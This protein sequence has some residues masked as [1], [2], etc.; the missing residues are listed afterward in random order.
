MTAKSPNNRAAYLTIGDFA[1]PWIKYPAIVGND[2]AGEVIEVGTGA[3]RFKIGDRVVALAVGTDKRSNKASES[4]FQECVVIRTHMA[5]QIPEFVSYEEVAVLPLALGTA[6]CGLYMIDQLA[7][8]HPMVDPKPN[9]EVLVVWGGSTSVGSNAIQ[10]AIASGYEV[11]TT[12]SPKNHAY[13]KR[14]GASAAFDY[15]SKTVA[16]D[17]IEAVGNRTLAGAIAIGE[18]STNPCI[19]I[20]AGCKGKKFVAQASLSGVGVPT[21]ILQ[22]IGMLFTMNWAKLSTW[23]KAKT[24]GVGYKFLWG[25]DLMANEVGKAIFEDF[26]PE[27]LARKQFVCAPEPQVVGHGLEKVQEALDIQKNGVSAKKIVITL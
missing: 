14:L 27:A 3:T 10:L 20:V 18:G 22:A 7:L 9:R 23:R 15:K 26:L 2:I 19:E 17:I 8:P 4:A 13:V 16:K 24:N 12:A 21:T 25:S 1:F 11:I 5:A 6:A